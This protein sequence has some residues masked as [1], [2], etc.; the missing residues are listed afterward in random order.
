MYLA[1]YWEIP[2]VLNIASKVIHRHLKI[3]STRASFDRATKTGK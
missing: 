1:S 3:K 2:F